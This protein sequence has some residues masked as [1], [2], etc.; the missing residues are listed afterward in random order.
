MKRGARA[1]VV[2]ERELAAEKNKVA[3]KTEV[4]LLFYNI[5]MV[6]AT[7]LHVFIKILQ[8]TLGNCICVH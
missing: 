6:M 7:L 4:A 8:L 3:L 5:I 1:Q 2:G